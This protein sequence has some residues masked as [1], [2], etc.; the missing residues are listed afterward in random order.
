MYLESS[1]KSNEEFNVFYR[2]GLS[3]QIEAIK[4]VG[5]DESVILDGYETI[6][7]PKSKTLHYHSVLKSENI[8]IEIFHSI[9]YADE[10]LL[11]NTTKK[12]LQNQ[13]NIV[14]KYGD[15][16]EIKYNA[17]KTVLMVFK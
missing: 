6:E 1:K 10:I 4:L 13:L 3:D 7:F 17:R 2:F 12:A 11:I 16:F 14:E 15:E 9:V 5:L 8:N